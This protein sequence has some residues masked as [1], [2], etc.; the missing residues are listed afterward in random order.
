MKI[1][2]NKQ[3]L[4][5]LNAC[6]SGFNLFV[7][8]HGEKPDVL[9]SECLTSNGWSDIWWLIIEVYEQLDVAQKN[10]VCLLGCDWA[11]SVLCNFESKYPDDKRPRLA[12]Q[13]KRDFIDGK[14]SK[15]ELS[16]AWSVVWSASR[17]AA[18]SAVESVAWSVAESVAELVAWSELWSAESE[19]KTDLMNLFLRW[20]KHNE[21]I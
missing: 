6:K 18:E 20:E 1:S 19:Q 12:I 8:A 3:E 10:E 21:K 7:K 15:D 14:V 11:E 13:A 2:T 16:A 4:I 5:G 9:F 17:S